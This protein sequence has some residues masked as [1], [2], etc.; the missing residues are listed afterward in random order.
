MQVVGGLAATAVPMPR[1]VVLMLADDTNNLKMLADDTNNLTM[2]SCDDITEAVG[3]SQICL[4]VF[5][6]QCTQT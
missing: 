6:G 4:T 1:L 3:S 2:M 5:F